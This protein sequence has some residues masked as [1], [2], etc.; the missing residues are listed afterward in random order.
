MAK[1]S[2]IPGGGLPRPTAAQ[3][4]QREAKS[5]RLTLRMHPDIMDILSMRAA[6]RGVSRSHLVEQILVG[7]MRADPRN[8]RMDA[9]GRIVPDAEAPL[10]LRERSPVQLADRWRKF[11]TA[12]EIVIG[13][14][15]SA[16]WLDDP[17]S[18]WSEDWHG[19]AHADRGPVEQDEEPA[20]GRAYIR[21]RRNMTD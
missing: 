14:P 9:V 5:N 16:E 2:K 15:P 20:A 8:P 18:Y 19:G 11:A 4:A 13:S 7:M 21:R 17:A 1:D 12:H 3:L 10:A 6:E